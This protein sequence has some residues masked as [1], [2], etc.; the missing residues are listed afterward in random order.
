MMHLSV[1]FI[2]T[3]PVLFIFHVVEALSTGQ[4][5]KKVSKLEFDK[6]MQEFSA[7]TQ[8]SQP[9]AVRSSSERRV[10]EPL[11]SESPRNMGSRATLDLLS[12]LRQQKVR[13]QCSARVM[14][15]QPLD[16]DKYL[17][18]V[19]YGCVIMLLYKH[20][21]FLQLCPVPIFIYLVK[22]AGVCSSKKL[23]LIAFL[24]HIFKG[25][26]RSKY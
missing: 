10:S 5:D 9:A 1:M 22:H 20:S 25:S 7:D 21:W 8:V 16:S 15:S 12:A 23:L 19:L 18:G 6:E 13:Q 2:S 11:P 4:L 3:F 26:L 14:Y 24:K 17:Y